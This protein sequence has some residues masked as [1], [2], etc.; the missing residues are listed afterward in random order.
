M[1]V[2]FVNPISVYHYRAV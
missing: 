1:D 2:D